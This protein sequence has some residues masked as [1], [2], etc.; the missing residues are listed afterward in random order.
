MIRRSK[1][2]DVVSRS[3]AE[4]KYRVMAHTVCEMVWL[5]NLIMEFGLDSPGCA[6]AL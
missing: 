1:K 2:Q 4:A 5:K 6:Y 3:S